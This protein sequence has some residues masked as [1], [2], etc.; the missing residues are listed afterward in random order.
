MC[1]TRIK[2]MICH[3]RLSK[4]KPAMSKTADTRPC[5]GCFAFGHNHYMISA[6]LNPITGD[7]AAANAA[8]N[9]L[10][11]S[12]YIRLKTPLGSWWRDVTLGSR[13]HELERE[14]DVTRVVTLAQQ[15]AEQALAPILNDG[16]ASFI[17]VVASSPEPKDAV[18]GRM[19]LQ[20]EMV[21]ASERRV[22]FDHYI[23]V[24]G[25]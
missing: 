16:R 6:Q 24:H 4:C 12:A 17:A 14:K 5:G 13:L 25:L 19:L 11:N 10:M 1:L 22:T 8:I 2:T 3:Y 23:Q 18:T 21:D 7:Y 9:H 20:I 15:Y